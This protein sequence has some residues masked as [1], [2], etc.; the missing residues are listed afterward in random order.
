MEEI[1][2]TIRNDQEAKVSSPSSGLVRV[3]AESD[4]LAA[5]I[6]SLDPIYALQSI[7]Q[8]A[9][10]EAKSIKPLAIQA[11]KA[12]QIDED[13]PATEQSQ[14]L[15]KAPR[16]SLAVH[17]LVP[18]MFRGQRDPVLVRRAEKV[19]Q[20]AVKILKK[21]YSCA[22]RRQAAMVDENGE[23]QDAARSNTPTRWILQLLLFSPE[24]MAASLT[25]CRTIPNLPDATWPNSCHPAGLANVD[26]VEAMPSSAYRK[27][28]EA[29]EC[30][31][32]L[33]PR[34][35][36]PRDE[37]PPVID[38]GACPGGW[39]AAL[40]RLGARVISVD[41]S[42]LKDDL[43][44]D[45]MVTFIKG[46]AFTYE[47]PWA[48]DS[49]L[50]TRAPEGTWM[51]SDVI[52]YPERVKELLDRWC[53]G[54]W[55][56]NMIVTAKFQGDTIPWKSL[57]AAVESATKH[58]YECRVKHFFNNKN[59]VTLMVSQPLKDK[60]CMIEKNEFF[61]GKPMYSPALASD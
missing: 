61:P 4:D 59:E 22:R 13:S 24:V 3:I 21:G 23:Q 53:G 16:G 58:G 12:L 44:Q 48:D 43:M 1:N 17:Y 25:K 9:V 34:S 33:P 56:G 30:M 8:C 15:R 39:T 49:R 38:L 37:V 2:R 18:G 54:K 45:D 11:L 55:A 31:Q 26:I 5:H 51:V 36:H 19:A 7:P 28:L 35:N 29:F 14:E 41:R 47:P 46:D 60:D 40:R 57:N 10:I 32:M 6:E 42:E 20:E 52:A 50:A 27:L